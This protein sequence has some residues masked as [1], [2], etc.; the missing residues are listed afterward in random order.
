M[1]GAVLSALSAGCLD[2]PGDDGDGDA[3]PVQLLANPDFEEDA[4]GW[5]FDGGVEIGTTM[6][7][8]LPPSD[9]GP[10][11][12]LL[13]REDNQMDRLDQELMVPDAASLE[14]T[15]V[16]CYST[17]EGFGEVYDTFT[18]SIEPIGGGTAEIL[19]EDSN[20]DA[21]SNDCEWLPFRREAAD[22]AGQRIRLVIEARTDEAGTTSF[23]IDG[24]ALTATR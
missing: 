7:L 8:G 24:L 6:E 3:P 22:F 18:I 5:S 20:L 12:A 4:E 23:A 15:G 9:E 11:V 13:G 16:R 14:L 2:A 21:T 19:V 1:T 10:H 17:A